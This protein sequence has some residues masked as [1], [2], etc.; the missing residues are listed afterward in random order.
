MTIEEAIEHF[1]RDL[2]IGQ[3]ERTVRTY[4]TALNHF[5]EFLDQSCFDPAATPAS[6][7]TSD[8]A[9]DWVR[10]L[11]EERQLAR[12]TLSTYTTA[13]LRF[14]SHLVLEGLIG[15][16]AEEHEQLQHRMHTIRGRTPHQQL[17][18]VPPDEVV[19]KIMRT[20]RAAPYDPG[21]HRQR[22][23][24]LR[25]IATVEM[26]RSSGMRVGELVSLRRGDLRPQDHTA[27]VTG[28]GNKQRIV[29]FDEPSW[30][31]MQSY[32]RIRQDGKTGQ[33]LGRLPVLARHDRGAG[34][35]ILP[36]STNTVRKVLNDLIKLAGVD[37]YGVTPHSFR[38]YF[39]TKVLE[40]TGDLGATQDL[41]GHASPNTTRIYAKLSSKIL[42]KAHEK[43]FGR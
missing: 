32:L 14:Y 20:A 28:K 25:N 30:R 34:D 3:A 23:R 41:L 40:A 17:P 1:L 6:K 24:H 19:A 7:L 12:V 29:Y 18:K 2:A 16:S 26:L 36:I 5:C 15:M 13:L 9:L 33:A 22:L 38:H 39:A 21:N 35:K 27:I 11:D 43:A 37:E 8:H 10:W 42:R 4:A 31:A